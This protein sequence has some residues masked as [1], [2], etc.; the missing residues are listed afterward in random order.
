M[1]AACAG[2]AK[3]MDNPAAPRPFL[4]TLAKARVHATSQPTRLWIGRGKWM[5][6]YAGM[7][8]KMDNPADPR[9]FLV[10]LAKRGSM[11]HLSLHGCG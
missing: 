1:D 11:Q 8:K 5:P 9:P 6:A 4:V 2:M 3:K 7:T 10:T